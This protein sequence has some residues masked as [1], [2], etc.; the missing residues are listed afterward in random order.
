MGFYTVVQQVG[1]LAVI[2]FVG[3][4]TA[5]IGYIDI[6]F[7]DAIS[8]LIVN[9]LLPCLIISSISSKELTKEL[10]G[11]LGMVAVM[12]AFCIAVLY[13]LGLVM[14]KIFKIPD[15]TRPVHIFLSCLG[16]VIFI[17]RPIVVA[18]FGED[19]FIYVIVF[20]L[21]NDLFLW[22]V[23]VFMLNK[24]EKNNVSPLK[25]LL[26]PNTISFAIAILMLILGIK[27]PPI[28]EPAVTGMGSLTTN[29]S[30]IFIGMA[31]AT[32]DV[33]N[34]LKKWWVFLIVPVKLIIMPI[35]F[36][37]IFRALGINYIISG[38]IVLEAAMPAMTV[39]SILAYEKKSD[40]EYATVGMFVTTILS[41]ATLPFV[42]YMFTIL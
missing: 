37:M 28:I 24:G 13:M 3:F 2:M 7:K 29:L 34:I 19:A 35:V 22:T 33:K 26:N 25:K 5:K 41:L 10:I 39:L 27:L 23:G 21:L 18:M 4:F 31:L 42:C 36:F 12:S 11:E 15:F 1:V 16:N 8:K 14:V 9:L 38:A 20:W 30:M 40:Y 6:K 32:V 17:G